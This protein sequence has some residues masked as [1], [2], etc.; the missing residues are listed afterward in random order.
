MGKDV[1]IVKS[2][3]GVQYAKMNADRPSYII[4]TDIKERTKENFLLDVLSRLEKDVSSSQS[5][6]LLM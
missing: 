2:E 1:D 5:T 4:K 6:C 3:L